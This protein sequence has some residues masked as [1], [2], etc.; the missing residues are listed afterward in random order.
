[1]YSTTLDTL[2]IISSGKEINSWDELW[3]LTLHL[4]E[5]SLLRQLR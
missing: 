1:M 4:E 5:A 2:H 3:L